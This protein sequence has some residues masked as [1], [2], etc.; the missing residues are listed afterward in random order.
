MKNHQVFEN[1]ILDDAPLSEAD[2][3]ALRTHLETCESCRRLAEN[4]SAVAT[5]FAETPVLVPAPGFS[6]RWLA[7]LDAQQTAERARNRRQAWAVAAIFGG[8]ALLSLV[9]LGVQFFRIYG[10]L[11]GFVADV[12]FR[13]TGLLILLVGWGSLTGTLVRT[14]AGLI[15]APVWVGLLVLSGLAVLLWVVAMAKFTHNQ[16]PLGSARP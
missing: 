12:F 13:M 10:S 16:R 1:W 4:W 9:L 2:A 14:F 15:P 8:V 5:L 3:Q 7:A 6:D 11:V